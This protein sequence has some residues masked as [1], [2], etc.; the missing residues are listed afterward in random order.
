MLNTY[1]TKETNPE[2][3]SELKTLYTTMMFVEKQR[4]VDWFTKYVF[5][6]TTKE[7]QEYIQA[8]E[9]YIEQFYLDKFAVC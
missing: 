7:K 5:S 3:N 8:K 4:L 1:L 2:K 9:E 6:E